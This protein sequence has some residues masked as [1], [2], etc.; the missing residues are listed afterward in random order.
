ME[1]KTECRSE[2]RRSPRPFETQ[3]KRAFFRGPSLPQDKLKPDLGARFMSEL[4][5][6][7]RTFVLGYIRGR[8]LRDFRETFALAA[9]AQDALKLAPTWDGGRGRLLLA[10]GY[11]RV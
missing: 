3:G 2:R 7:P 6:F 4:K 11:G 10:E 5:I 1:N 8:A 9:I